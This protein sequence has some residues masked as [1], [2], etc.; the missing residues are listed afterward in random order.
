MTTRSAWTHAL[1]DPCWARR[2]GDTVPHRDVSGPT[3]A[4]NCCQCG[5]P[6]YG[7]YIRED[8]A[9]MRCKGVHPTS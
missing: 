9:Q 4:E 1:C 2:N 6:C 7:I 5:K 8:P 3:S